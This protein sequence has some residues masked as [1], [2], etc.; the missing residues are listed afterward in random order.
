MPGLGKVLEPII[1]VLEKKFKSGKI[2]AFIYKNPDILVTKKVAHSSRQIT[3]EGVLPGKLMSRIRREHFN[4]VFLFVIHLKPSVYVLVKPTHNLFESEIELSG[5]AA[6]AGAGP[7]FLFS[8]D[9]PLGLL[10]FEEF[11]SEVAG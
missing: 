3:G 5:T 7:K 1:R 6:K 8:M 11:L 10:I 9:S 2:D 4:L